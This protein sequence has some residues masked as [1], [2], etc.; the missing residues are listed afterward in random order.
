MYFNEERM[1][2]MDSDDTQKE[3][4]RPARLEAIEAYCAAVAQMER[5]CDQVSAA[6]RTRDIAQVEA[7]ARVGVA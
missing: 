5:A 4:D 6:L 1:F 7:G 3:I 2:G